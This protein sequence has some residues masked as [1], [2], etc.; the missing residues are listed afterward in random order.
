LEPRFVSFL[1]AYQGVYPLGENELLFIKEAYRFFILNYVVRGGEH[2]FRPSI[3]RRLQ[4][5]AIAQYLPSLDSL[6]LRPLAE[7]ILNLG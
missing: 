2:F 1:K 4:Q 5:E 7:R 6:D 3:C